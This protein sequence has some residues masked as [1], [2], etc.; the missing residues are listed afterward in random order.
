[1][2]SPYGLLSDDSWVRIQRLAGLS[3]WTTTSPALPVE[4][5]P[6]TPV[7]SE[8]SVLGPR[9]EA[10]VLV[11]IWYTELT[12]TKTWLGPTAILLSDG[13]YPLAPAPS[14]LIPLV[15]LMSGPGEVCTAVSRPPPRPA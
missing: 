13:A 6:P 3:Y 1:M 7:H 9:I 5:P 2:H 12:A 4:H 14:K 8:L 10:P 15:A 11:K